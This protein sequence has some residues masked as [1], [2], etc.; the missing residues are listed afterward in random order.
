MI[1]NRSNIYNRLPGGNVGNNGLRK[2]SSRNKSFSGIGD[3]DFFMCSLSSSPA[4]PSD[5]D[6]P[7]E[8]ST[9]ISTDAG[10]GSKYSLLPPPWY[11]RPTNGSG[12]EPRNELRIFAL[13]IF[14]PKSIFCSTFHCIEL[15]QSES[16]EARTRIPTPF[17]NLLQ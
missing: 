15:Q 14:H 13:E 11:L 5:V 17:W 16:S 7:A 8:V 12:M 9:M 2:R 6:E 1:C 3:F 4:A 10:R